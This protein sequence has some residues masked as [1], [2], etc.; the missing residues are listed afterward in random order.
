MP[1]FFDP[2][3]Q[4]SL[5]TRVAT[6][7][8]DAPALWG[9]MNAAQMLAHCTSTMQM[10]TGEVKVKAG[11]MSLLGRL[12]KKKILGDQPFRH[13]APTDKA[14]VVADT[15]EFEVE[16]ARFLDMFQTLTHGTSVITAHTHPFF[17]PMTDEDW[18]VLL[19][20]HLDHHL[21][22]FGV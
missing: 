22:Q 4:A 2:T 12:L 15:R 10:P 19:F 1:T 20:K 14:F 7:R 18:G 21:R 16:K 13:G 8:A 11:F 17:G 9:R 3:V 6:L 5:H